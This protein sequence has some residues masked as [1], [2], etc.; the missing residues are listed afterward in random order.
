M[1]TKR[2]TI[3]ETLPLFPLLFHLF[4]FFRLWSTDIGYGSCGQLVQIRFEHQRK[5]LH[6]SSQ[7]FKYTDRTNNNQDTAAVTHKIKEPL[8]IKGATLLNV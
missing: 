4:L 6:M 7:S 3:K 2:Q 5:M 8:V 1:K